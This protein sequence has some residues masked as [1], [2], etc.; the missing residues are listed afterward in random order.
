MQY[1]NF[2]F[3]MHEILKKSASAF[4]KMYIKQFQKLRC[5]HSKLD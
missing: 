4:A 3:I 5:F 1:A 2:F